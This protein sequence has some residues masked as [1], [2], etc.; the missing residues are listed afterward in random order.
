MA[1]AVHKKGAAAKL[2]RQCRYLGQLLDG[3]N[4]VASIRKGIQVLQRQVDTLVRQRNACLH[5]V[6]HSCC[7]QVCLILH[8]HLV[9]LH[10][11]MDI[12]NVGRR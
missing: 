4:A 11:V 1:P 3:E 2:L 8:M 7:A 12:V 5:T 10:E 6:C 9:W